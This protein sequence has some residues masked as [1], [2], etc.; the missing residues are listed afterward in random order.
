MLP[1][2]VITSATK[3]AA[4]QPWGCM[5]VVLGTMLLLLLGVESQDEHRVP[6]QWDLGWESLAQ[7]GDDARS[8]SPAVTAW[9]ATRDPATGTEGTARPGG[10]WGTF[11]SL[12]PGGYHATIP[13][14][15]RTLPDGRTLPPSP[16]PAMDVTIPVPVP[17]PS[18]AK[19]HPVGHSCPR[20]QGG[21][22]PPSHGVAGHSSHS[23]QRVPQSHG[24][25]LSA[26][27]AR[28]AEQPAGASR[29][30]PSLH[31]CLPSRAEPSRAMGPASPRPAQPCWA[32][33]AAAMMRSASLRRARDPRRR[34]GG[35]A[36][37]AA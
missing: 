31:P 35:R 10:L 13:Q 2:Q 33:R 30:S 5:C 26:A 29:S 12:S 22:T 7:P 34:R 9:S 27:E 16:P 20:P 23:R 14:T 15:G 3:R 18:R 32:P 21:V 19:C 4:Q 36:R 28:E 6:G 8:D 24:L 37:R 17:V 1:V 11:V 25:A